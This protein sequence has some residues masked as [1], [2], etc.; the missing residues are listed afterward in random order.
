M[1]QRTKRI[2]FHSYR[3]RFNGVRELGDV[4]CVFFSQV[5]SM[6]GPESAL[7]GGMFL[8]GSLI[9]EYKRG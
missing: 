7:F 3:H 6:W 5:F 4:G 9:S 8:F 2:M 1:S